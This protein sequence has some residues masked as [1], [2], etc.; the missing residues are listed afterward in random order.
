MPAMGVSP[1]RRIIGLAAVVKHMGV[2]RL[3]GEIRAVIHAQA[4]TT[5][6]EAPPS[7]TS[8]VQSVTAYASL[9]AAPPERVVLV[10]IN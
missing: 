10:A 1:A 9:D 4:K 5:A 7:I 6:V 2:I 8:D 3:D